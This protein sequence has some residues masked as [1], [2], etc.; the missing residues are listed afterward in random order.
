LVAARVVD[1]RPAAVRPLDEVKAVIR[2]RLERDEA[3]KLARTAGEEKTRRIAQASQRG[4][5]LAA[6]H[7]VASCPQ[8]LPQNLLNEVL[9]TRADKL[10]AYVGAEVEGA[11][12]LI[13]NVVS[14]KEPQR[15][16]R[17]SARPSG[18]PCS[19]RLPPPTRWRTPKV[20]ASGTRPLC[21]SRNSG[22]SRR[23]P[24]RRRQVFGEVI[25]IG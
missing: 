9:L 10:P 8:G 20:C 6:D 11:G 25:A 23:R 12:F 3:A 2:Q 5:I 19:G 17:P 13:A 4:G 7:G 22:A 21:S 14:A 24:G 18:P 16:C 15:S 1:H